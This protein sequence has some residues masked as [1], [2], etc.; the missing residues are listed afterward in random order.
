[1][2]EIYELED[3]QMSMFEEQKNTMTDVDLRSAIE[4]QMSKIRTQ[5]MLLGFQVSCSSVLNKIDEVMSKPGKRSMNDY[6]RLIKDIEKFCKTGISRQVNE[7]GTTAIIEN[8]TVQ[9]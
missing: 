3:G 7:D 5:A 2:S 6:K 9:N 8:E 1:M 4:D